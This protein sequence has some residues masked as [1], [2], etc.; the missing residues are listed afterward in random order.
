[1]TATEPRFAEASQL[2]GSARVLRG[3]ETAVTEM[4]LARTVVDGAFGS[5]QPESVPGP[6]GQPVHLAAPR[7]ARCRPDLRARRL[8]SRPGRTGVTPTRPPLLTTPALPAHKTP[9]SGAARAAKLAT[10][11]PPISAAMCASI[12]P[13]SGADRAPVT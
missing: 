12:E 2:G 6:E 5:P 4:R 13:C 7:L 9:R 3:P 1:M 11:F 10:R 8:E